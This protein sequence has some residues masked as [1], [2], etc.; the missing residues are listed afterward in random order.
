MSVQ[1]T[2]PSSLHPKSHSRSQEGERILIENIHD[3]VAKI[4]EPGQTCDAI[5]LPFICF[6]TNRRIQSVQGMMFPVG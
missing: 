5:E 2:W 4:S 3:S 6:S 1:T